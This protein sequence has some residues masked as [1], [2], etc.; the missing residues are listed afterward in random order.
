MNK[1]R[2][3][4]R[5]LQEARRQHRRLVRSLLL[6]M[7]TLLL[8]ALLL[9]LLADHLVSDMRHYTFEDANLIPYNKVGV[10]LGTSKYLVDGR[11]NEYFQNRIDAAVTLFNHGKISYF[12]V[13]G[14]NATR[15][16]NEPRE[17]RRELIRAG[18]PSERIY[19]DYA[20]F[21]TLDSIVRANAVFGQRNYTIIS[22]QFHNERALYLARHFGIQAI[23]FNAR[24]VDAY[25]GLKTRVRELM[26]RVLCLLDVYI[27]DKQP[28]FLGDPILIG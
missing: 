3:C 5:W 10:I 2:N 6:G 4:L 14:D 23:G 28:K 16:Y 12:L 26:A 8:L 18:I 17:M 21:R 25:S 1:L 20:G 24:D 15:S 13:S 22:Q 11:R 27:L 9:V 19:S 7:A